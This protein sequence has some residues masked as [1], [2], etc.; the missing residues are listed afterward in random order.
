MRGARVGFVPATQDWVGSLRLRSR[1][2]PGTA[3]RGGHV[4]PSG[5][6]ER[7]RSTMRRVYASLIAV[8]VAIVLFRVF[9]PRSTLAGAAVTAEVLWALPAVLGGAI[10]GVALVVASASRAGLAGM[11]RFGLPDFGASGRALSNGLTWATIGVLAVHFTSSAF[12][13]LPGGH[14]AVAAVIG[15]SLGFGT[16]RLHRHAIEHDAYRTFNLV[17]L[18]LASG[19]LASMSITPTGEWWTRNFST[20][21]TSDD[22]AAACFNVAIIV[23]GAGMAALSGGL[24]LA[25]V[26]DTYRVRRGRL[27]TMRALI[28]LIGLGLMGVGMVPIDGDTVLHNVFA[29]TA[30][31]AFAFLCLSMMVWAARM[32]RTLVALS[33]A[34]LALEVFA[35]FAYDVL[36]LFNLTVFEIIAFTLVFAW[37]IALVATTAGHAHAVGGH[38]DSTAR[39]AVSARYGT[40]RGLSGSSGPDSR[41]TPRAPHGPRGFA[42]TTALARR[43]TRRAVQPRHQQRVRW[44]RDGHVDDPPDAAAFAR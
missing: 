38:H 9:T 39:H 26:S 17:A 20:L 31:G 25:L 33:Y 29:A 7:G 18:L 24:T 40:R 11:A 32:P 42:G 8:A 43:V 16:Y 10:V 4:R 30:A 19:S 2:V 23:S 28:A 44:R 34:A 37:L 21:G 27:V 22:I 15:A 5:A 36:G 12:D 14:H 41:T 35:L 6:L 13:V 3:D 1:K